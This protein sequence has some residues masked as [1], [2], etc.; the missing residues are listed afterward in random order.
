MGGGGVVVLATRVG[1]NEWYLE[2]MRSFCYGT[3]DLLHF[4][5]SGMCVD[6]NVLKRP[7]EIHLSSLPTA[8]SSSCSPL[9]VLG[10]V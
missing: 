3:A 7:L 2:G 6:V 9:L 4:R 10:A 8:A 1:G 5:Q